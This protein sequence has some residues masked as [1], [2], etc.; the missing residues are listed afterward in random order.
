MMTKQNLAKIMTNSN[1]VGEELT[2]SGWARSV[3]DGKENAFIALNDGSCVANLQLVINKNNFSEDDLNQYY[4]ITTGASL[5]A[6]GI[7]QCSP[8]QGQSVELVVSS[9]KILGESPSDYPLQKKATSMEFLR[10]IAHLRPRTNTFGAV[11]RV[12]SSV[13]YAIHQFFHERSFVYLNAPLITSSDAEGAGEM[14][15]V[16]TLPL[17][18]LRGEVDYSRDFFGKKT[19]LTVSGQLAGEA[20]ALALGN[21]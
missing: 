18:K 12:R 6:K 21:I 3:R 16:T 19:H 10:D 20:Y 14:F 5:Q 1:L 2:I 4:K 13:S 15:Q 8:A 17:D 7:L 11:M 9:L